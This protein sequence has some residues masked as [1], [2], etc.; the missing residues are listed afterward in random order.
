MANELR[1]FDLSEDDTPETRLK[2]ES[3]AT[4]IVDGRKLRKGSRMNRS[5]SRPRH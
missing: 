4:G 2:R 5:R 3:A 1:G